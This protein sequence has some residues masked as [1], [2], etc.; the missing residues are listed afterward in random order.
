[1]LLGLDDP[2]PVVTE[3]RPNLQWLVI[4]D[5]ASNRIPGRLKQLGLDQPKIDE[6]IAWDIGAA[7]V[8]RYLAQKLDAP[9]IFC[10]YSRLVIDCNRYPDAADSAPSISDGIAVPGNK[11][12]SS[13]SRTARRREIFEPYHEA[14]SKH[15]DAALAAGHCPIILSIHSCTPRMNDVDRPWHIGLAWARDDR[16]TR[17]VL[18][19]LRDLASGP[20]GD[21]MPYDLEFGGDFTTPEHAMARGLA[22]LQVEFRND[23]VNTYDTACQQADI[24][25]R[26]IVCAAADDAAMAECRRVQ[27]YLQPTDPVRYAYAHNREA[28]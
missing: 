1:M 25:Y 8:A 23:L 6:H 12:L 18:A 9:S 14:I 13:L 20:V 27:H 5:H 26:A 2:Q 16:F 11:D 22:H 15:L 3:M 21:N 10:N 19:A 28:C 7:D 4:C 24:L 17:P